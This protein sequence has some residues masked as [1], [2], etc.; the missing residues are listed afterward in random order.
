[1]ELTAQRTPSLPNNT[2][3]IRVD[4]ALV[5]HQSKLPCRANSQFVGCKLCTKHTNL[6]SSSILA[7]Y[8][9]K[10]RTLHVPNLIIRFGTCKVRHLNWA[11][12]TNP[13][14]QSNLRKQTCLASSAPV[15]T[16]HGLPVWHHQLYSNQNCVAGWTDFSMPH[17]GEKLLIWIV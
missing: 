2:V 14:L 5:L 17:R 12:E 11:L 8:I 7:A 13:R 9:Y 4:S 1:M 3:V 6:R 16:V 10:R 15:T